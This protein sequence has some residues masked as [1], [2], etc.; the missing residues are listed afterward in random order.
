MNNTNSGFSVLDM[1]KEMADA[2]EVDVH[3]LFIA[4]SNNEPAPAP[5]TKEEDD[6]KDRNLD[7]WEPDES[8]LEGMDEFSEGPVTYDKSEIREE[9][10]GPLVNNAEESWSKEGI[11]KM[12]EL[13]RYNVNIDAAKR[14][15]GISK[16][17]IPEGKFHVMIMNAAGDTNYERAQQELDKIFNHIKT[18]YP[19]FILEWDDP[20]KN[21]PSTATTHVKDKSLIEFPVQAADGKQIPPDPIQTQDGSVE[22]SPSEGIT[23][24][25][26]DG[27]D[28]KIIIDKTDLPEISWTAEE[29]EKIK[30]SRSIELNIV[31]GANIEMAQ[32]EEADG[33]VIDSIL[34]TY[35]RRV[36]DVTAALPASKYRATFTGLTYPEVID[37]TNSREMNT[38]DSERKKWTICFNHIKNPSIGEWRSYIWYIDPKTK[39]RVEVEDASMVPVDIET[40]NIISKFED[41][42]MKTSYL[43]L[44]FMLWKILCATAM[45]K[46]IISINCHNILDN[47]VECGHSYDWIYNPADLLLMDSI[48]PAVLEEMRITGEAAGSEE[49]LKNY[50]SSMLRMNNTVTLKTSGLVAI[51]GHASGYDYL[52]NIYPAIISLDD[53]EDQTSIISKGLSYTMLSSVKGFLVPVGDGKYKK[54]T[55]INNIIKII[56]SLDE[57]DWQTLMKVIELTVKPYA[58]RYAIRGLVCPKCKYRSSVAIESISKLLF[59]VAQSISSVQVTLKKV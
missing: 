14:R 31:E 20:E 40:Y 6:T 27:E 47:G 42:M 39:K 51:F 10:D 26:E 48:M 41:F 35:Q 59:I 29:M 50:N 4:Q 43:D 23:N 22:S 19:E 33:N 45:E 13:S 9:M 1:A 7:L 5:E 44:E 54:V 36:N 25:Q 24:V 46:E 12:D 37:L 58:F 30:K 11:E 3:D 49:I 38:I 53:E 56:T 28:L 55:G 57:F 52:E 15:H 32:I 34:S 18:T 17:Q 21:K 8:L 2:N 16:F